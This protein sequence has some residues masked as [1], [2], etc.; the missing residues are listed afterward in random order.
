M[1]AAGRQA[2]GAAGELPQ[3]AAAPG[4]AGHRGAAVPFRR[5]RRRPG[6]E[7]ERRKP[8]GR[9]G[10]A[11]AGMFPQD[12]GHQ[13]GEGRDLNLSLTRP[14]P[15]SL[16][17]ASFTAL[18]RC[19]RTEPWASCPLAPGAGGFGRPEWP[20]L[21]VCVSGEGQCLLLATVPGERPG[22]AGPLPGPLSALR[23]WARRKIKLY[24]SRRL[25]ACVG[26][27]NGALARDAALLQEAGSIPSPS[28]SP[29]VP[30]EGRGVNLLRVPEGAGWAAGR[31]TRI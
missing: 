17:P 26:A 9:G 19:S 27:G 14:R 16:P 15:R 29:V 13:G 22:P 25:P 8:R 28:R 21:P 20:R 11:T 5:L 23:G 3:L 1:G 2:A 6:R 31:R 4:V 24:P 12:R 10:G 7:G 30:S 18:P